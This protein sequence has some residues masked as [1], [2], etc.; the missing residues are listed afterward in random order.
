MPPSQCLSPHD[1]SRLGPAFRGIHLV[2]LSK[3]V[4]IGTASVCSAIRAC[5]QHLSGVCLYLAYWT[6]SSLVA[7]FQDMR[8]ICTCLHCPITCVFDRLKASAATAYVGS[9]AF[10][11]VLAFSLLL[12]ENCKLFTHPV[13]CF[14]AYVGSCCARTIALPRVLHGHDN[15]ALL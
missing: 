8:P 15:A 10:S 1:G 13:I 9:R 2:I 12:S 4:K 3:S 11:G 7:S 6:P 5:R 14:L